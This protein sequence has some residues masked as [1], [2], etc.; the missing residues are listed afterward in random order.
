LLGAGFRGG[1]SGEDAED[2]FVDPRASEGPTKGSRIAH[3]VAQQK[4]DREDS[5]N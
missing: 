2:G 5:D 4:H 1:K 3:Y